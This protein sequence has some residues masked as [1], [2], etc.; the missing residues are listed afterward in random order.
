[1]NLK[2]ATNND[3]INSLIE[4]CTHYDFKKRLNAVDA[5]K[6]LQAIDF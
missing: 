2:F 5:L 4:N 1:M 3:L 6:K